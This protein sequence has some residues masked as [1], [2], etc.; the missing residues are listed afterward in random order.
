[1][2]QETLFLFTF[3]ALAVGFFG[4]VLFGVW[5]SGD[6]GARPADSFPGPSAPAMAERIRELEAETAR[7]PSGLPAWIELGNLYFDTDQPRKAIEAYRRALALDP[8]NADV[9]TDLGVMYR[10]E[11]NPEEAVRCFERAMAIDPRHEISRLNKGIVLLHD[12][13]DEAGAIRAW[14]ELLA[15]NPLA[16]VPGG[17]TVDRMVQ[18]LKQKASAKPS[19]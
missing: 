4:G 14:E 5:R 19:G 18:G 9:W 10:K 16:A 15:I 11:G 17:M 2:R 3:L 13:R 1:M 8:E 6:D 12:L 7:N